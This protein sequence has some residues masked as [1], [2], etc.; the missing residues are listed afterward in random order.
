MKT[1]R[2][3]DHT[4]ITAEQVKKV[5][6]KRVYFG[7]QSVGDNIVQG[8]R[9]LSIEDGVQMNILGPDSPTGSGPMFL[10]FYIGENGN[11][12]SKNKAFLAFL[13]KG[14]GQRGGVALFKYCYADF[15]AHTDVNQVFQQYRETVSTIKVKYPA[16][17]LVHV[18]VPLARIDDPA[19]K[20]TIKS[21]LG[22]AN[23]FDANAKRNQFNEMLQA[24]FA[25]RDPIFDL[26]KVES[27]RPDGSRA[28]VNFR[29]HKVFV[30]SPELTDDGGHLNA[31]GR[32]NAA[33]QLV[34]TLASL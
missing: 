1:V 32:R 2:V 11:I 34:I 8:L 3:A 14:A 5:A 22:R 20:A 16:L 6:S 30:L 31:F 17:Q 29:N 27:T 28:F 19:W 7:H 9:E 21:Y 4:S 12:A 18:T 24:E 13:A 23:S 25:G 15:S 10:E 26:A 33:E